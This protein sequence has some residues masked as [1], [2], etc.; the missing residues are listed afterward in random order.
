MVVVAETT[1]G[2]GGCGL[3]VWFNGSQNSKFGYG[4][5]HVCVYV[6]NIYIGRVFAETVLKIVK[7]DTSLVVYVF[8]HV[9]VDCT[10]YF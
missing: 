10:F 3:L 4:I 6:E 8:G 9:L 7:L 2:M 5:G 1:R